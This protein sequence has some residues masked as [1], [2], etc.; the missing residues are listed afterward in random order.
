MF[1]AFDSRCLLPRFAVGSQ[2]QEPLAFVDLGDVFINDKVSNPSLAVQS[3]LPPL[4]AV[5]PSSQLFLLRT[6]SSRL[7]LLLLPTLPRSC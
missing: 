4:R 3:A 5:H 1:P 7:L 6:L 2:E